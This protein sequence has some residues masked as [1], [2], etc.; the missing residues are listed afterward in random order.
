MLFSLILATYGRYSEVDELLK[1]F[2]EQ[3]IGRNYFEVIVV[4]QN[5]QIDLM[6][7]IL[8]YNH[9]IDIKHIKSKVKGLSVNR[10]IGLR[11]A[12]GQYV[13]FP[14][15]DC[16]YYPNT[17]SKV[18]MHFG[19]NNINVVLGA[20]RDRAKGDNIIRNWPKKEK[21]ITKFNFFS[22]YSSISI[23]GRRNNIEFNEY[24]GVGCY[25]GSCEDAEYIY[26][27]INDVGGCYYFPDVEVWHPK[28]GVREFSKEKNISYGLGFGAFCAMHKFDVF[29]VRLFLLSL[30]YHFMCVI[31]SFVKCDYLSSARRLD[32]I[33][34]RIKGFREWISR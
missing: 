12:Q 9:L 10:N 4:D 19:D 26:R 3:D 29:I 23:F 7:L 17:L 5:D 2:T 11:L 18:L 31:V 14:D 13:C 16:T 27:L 34:S 30:C 1:S 28:I 21:K 24:L 22:L 15:D 32:A 20:I 8:K 33:S 6:P 25:F